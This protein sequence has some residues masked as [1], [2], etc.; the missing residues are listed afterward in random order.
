[1]ITAGKNAITMNIALRDR[2][3]AR[4]AVPALAAGGRRERGGC[5]RQQE[6]R[7]NK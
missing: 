2:L 1:M 4:L 6:N 3:V 5:R 7:E